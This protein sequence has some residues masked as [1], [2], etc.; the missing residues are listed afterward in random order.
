[1]KPIG[2]LGGTFDPVHHGHLRLALEL[3]DALDLA[4]VRFIPLRT[5]PHRE[6]PLAGRDL[7][8]AML[9]AAIKDEAGLCVDDRELSREGPSYTINT[10][11]SLREEL[12][13]TPLCLIMGMDAFRTLTSWHDWTRLPELAHIVVVDRPGARLTGDVELEK[14]LAERSVE[15]PSALHDQPAGHVFL[16][17]IPMLNITASGI[18]AMIASGRSPRFL[19]PSS[20]LVLIHQHG[21]YADS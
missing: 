13:N 9:E 11:T 3:Y 5:A 16:A 14:L 1:M 2:I 17:A 21:L 18:R 20:V 19:L 10:L 7:R 12:S 8:C 15:D 4:E 6:A